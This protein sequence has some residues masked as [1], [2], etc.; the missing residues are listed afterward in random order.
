MN[1]YGGG[2]AT[3]GGRLLGCRRF[4][5][6]T[7]G[8]A[9]FVA[10]LISPPLSG[11]RAVSG[12]R[13][14]RIALHLLGRFA[15]LSTEVVLRLPRPLP[16]GTRVG[17]ADPGGSGLR[18]QH[19]AWLFWA[20]LA[21]QMDLDHGSILLLIDTHSGRLVRGG[22]LLRWPLVNGRLPAFLRSSAAYASRR[23]RVLARAGART[24]RSPDAV[25][26]ISRVTRPQAA[27][28]A[29]QRAGLAS[30]APGQCVIVVGPE[31]SYSRDWNW[32]EH[33][34]DAAKFTALAGDLGIGS[35]YQAYNLAQLSDRI[36]LAQ[37]NGC[38]Q[39]TIFAT[40]EGSAPPG[41]IDPVDGSGPYPGNP[42]A[43]IQLPGGRIYGPDLARVLEDRYAGTPPN[44]PAPSF[45]LILQGCFSGRMIPNLQGVPGVSAVITSSGPS[46]EATRETNFQ[47]IFNVF[48]DPQ[49]SPFVSAIVTGI[50]NAF[51][52]SGGEIGAA[53][54]AA[55]LNDVTPS[56]DAPEL[57]VNGHIISKSPPAAGCTQ[58]HQPG[59]ATYAGGI[60][61]GGDHRAYA[62]GSLEIQVGPGGYCEG[63]TSCAFM[64]C[65]PACPHLDTAFPFGTRVTAIATPGPNS[66]FAR[67]D[68]G[69]CAGQGST[70]TFTASYD[71]CI[72]AEFLLSNPTAPP[73]SLPNIACREDPNYASPARAA[74]AA[75]WGAGPAPAIDAPFVRLSRSP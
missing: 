37:G 1:C 28:A 72:T 45:T 61:D 49:A 18:L 19:S 9:A 29:P 6:I 3:S 52:G 32:A 35:V 70:C 22:T 60:Y 2:S 50:K 74:P 33:Y 62:V 14:D 10:S 16:D 47:K 24:L 21:P 12:A 56:T 11:A 75:R 5:A 71:S 27:V 68:Q 43:N 40:G 39:I 31:P 54:R 53:A 8:S 46:T 59:C 15:R 51:N 38:S 63:R 23:Y 65:A 34:A 69:V 64:N 55:F 73:Q 48:T 30:A 13:A 67:W 20:D 26:R 36:G 66:Q 7:L 42:R 58:F 41:W 17:V 4:A 25:H 57:S 44:V